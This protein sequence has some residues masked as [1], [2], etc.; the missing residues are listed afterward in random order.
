MDKMLSI[1]KGK[2]KV[3]RDDEFEKLF[4]KMEWANSVL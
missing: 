1:K 4:Y 2:M 3:K